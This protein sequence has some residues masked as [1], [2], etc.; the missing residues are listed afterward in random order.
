MDELKPCPN[1]WCDGKPAYLY[2]RLR[3]DGMR[4][5]CAKC[6]IGP[7]LAPT[8]AEAIAAWNTRPAPSP[9]DAGLVVQQDGAS[10]G[11]GSHEPSPKGLGPSGFDPSRDD[12]AC[13]LT[14]CEDLVRGDWTPNKAIYLDLLATAQRLNAR[15]EA[16]SGEYERGVED[17]ARWHD[18]RYRKTPDAFEMEF[19]DVSRKAIRTLKEGGGDGR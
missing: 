9:A 13:Y 5:V 10:F 2:G 19:H 11:P 3:D 4:Y 17:A 12:D 1:P 7:P 14:A 15:I 16:L 8:E 18:E 6:G